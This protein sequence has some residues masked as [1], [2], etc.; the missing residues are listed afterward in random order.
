M[1][2]LKLQYFGHLMWK[3]T[4]LEKTLM[5][6]KIE[7]KRRSGR[8]RMRWLG[9]I[10]DAVDMSLNKFQE[11]VKDREAWSAAVR[12]VTK[13]QTQLS[14]WK[15]A[16]TVPNTVYL[17]REYAE[18]N[19]D[20]LKCRSVGHKSSNKLASN[21]SSLS[22]NYSCGLSFSVSRFASASL[23]VPT[24]SLSSTFAQCGLTCLPTH[25]D[26]KKL[27]QLHLWEHCLLSFVSS[28][29]ED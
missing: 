23:P 9:G 16:T 22:P 8:Q 19:T 12:G 14:D 5:L 1:L 26:F 21:G 24:P 3:A 28:T 20:W 2:K 6:G 17:Q 18:L 29:F 7:G 15:T 11:I 27:T 25:P 10:T 4:S 13:S